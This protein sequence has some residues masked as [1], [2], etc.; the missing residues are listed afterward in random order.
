MLDF[1]TFFIPATPLSSPFLHAESD[2]FSIVIRWRKIMDLAFI[3]GAASLWGVM[4]LLVWG[5]QKLEKPEGG[6]S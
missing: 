1:Y 6:R 3:L 2:T 5:F 4:V